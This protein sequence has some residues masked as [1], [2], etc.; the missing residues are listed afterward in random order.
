[1]TLAWEIFS[2]IAPIAD[3]DRAV[4]AQLPGNRRQLALVSNV[5]I[6]RATRNSEVREY[7]DLLEALGRV[8]EDYPS[9]L[10]FALQLTDDHYLDGYGFDESVAGQIT[11]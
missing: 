6:F 2:G 4:R 9:Q 10:H 7:F 5:L 8:L 1:M 11:E 3:V